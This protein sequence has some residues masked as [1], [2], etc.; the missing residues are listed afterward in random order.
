VIAGRS[1]GLK[2]VF[3]GLLGV[4][5]EWYLLS[6]HLLISVRPL[7]TRSLSQGG[8]QEEELPVREWVRYLELL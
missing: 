6:L 4:S 8:T 1:R 7:S 5:T 3:P 2:R